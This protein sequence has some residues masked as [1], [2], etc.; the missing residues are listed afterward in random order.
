MEFPTFKELLALKRIDE[1]TFQTL[2][3]PLQMGNALPIAYGGCAI[4]WACQ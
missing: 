3:N 4:S 2:E 1:S